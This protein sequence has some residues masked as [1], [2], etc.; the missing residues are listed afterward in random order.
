MIFLFTASCR[1]ILDI[2]QCLASS[3]AFLVTHNGLVVFNIAECC[4]SDCH[5][6]MD[7]CHGLSKTGLKRIQGWPRLVAKKSP[8]ELLRKIRKHIVW[9]QHVFMS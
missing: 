4:L 5:R 8:W 2:L 1:A 7:L 6:L 3:V 9:C